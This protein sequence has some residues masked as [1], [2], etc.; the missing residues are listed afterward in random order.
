MRRAFLMLGLAVLL[1][2][3]DWPRF[4]GPNGS[5]ISDDSLPLQWTGSAVRW[6]VDLDG[7]GNGSPIVVKD[8]VYLQTAS[9]DGS[10]RSLVALDANSGNER[11]TATISSGKGKTH[12]KNSMASMTP[13]CDG[14]RIYCTFWD[15]AAMSLTAFDLAGKEVWS[16]PLGSFKSQHGAGISPM[17][18]FGKVFVNFDQ[19]D[20]AEFIAFDARTGDKV[21]SAKRKAFRACY[22]TPHF[23]KR[24][25]KTDLVVTS[26]AGVTGYDPHTGAV[27]WNW[28][29]TFDGMALRTVASAIDAG[30][31]I[32]VPSGDGGGSR[33]LIVLDP[34]GENGK[35]NVA[36]Q[37]KKDT[38]YVPVPVVS[39]SHLFWLTDNGFA[40]CV[41]AKTGRELWRERITTAA[42]SSSPVLVRSATKEPLVI[43]I[44][45]TGQAVTFKA[46]PEGFEKVAE[47]QLGGSTFATPAVANNRMY[48]RVGN[49]LI[50]IGKDGA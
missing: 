5:G 49:R 1:A 15:G 30:N 13:A 6:S 8:T 27:Q 29:W 2:G 16:K 12:A 34:T 11:W 18:G 3:A 45:E 24:G 20:A 25:D 10:K 22:S 9:K 43:A 50:C 37:K 21:W 31:L 41:E 48:L 19:D 46:R 42:I 40:L 32:V 35:P 36:W 14:E 33:H 7:T 39:G 38:P 28:D 23:R 47:N 26:T 4:R 17:V 44:S